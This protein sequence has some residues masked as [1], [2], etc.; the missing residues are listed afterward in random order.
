MRLFIY[1]NFIALLFSVSIDTQN[2]AND[3]FDEILNTYV[4]SSG[5]VNY[6]GILDNP[7]NFNQYFDFI[8]SVSPR[9]HPEYFKTEKDK[10]A[11]WINAYNALTIKIMIENPEVESILDIFF[12][13]AIFK[14]KHLVGGEK[15]SLEDIEHK[16]LRKK[17]KEPRIHFAI[18]CASISCPPLGDRIVKGETLDAQLDKKAT[19]FIN[20]TSNVHIDHKEKRIYL[21]KIFKWFKKDFGNVREYICSYLADG[22]NCSNISSYR[23]SYF[24]YNWESNRQQ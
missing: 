9:N 12:S 10:I 16:I 11:Y 6:K 7:Y 22:N 24:D 17:Y 4:D 2:N 1:I 15:I 21:N 19:E 20:N 3:S 14:K 13:Y 23:I 5:N 18:N 8:E